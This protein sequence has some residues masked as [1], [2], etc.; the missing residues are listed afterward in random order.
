MS[1]VLRS[2]HLNFLDLSANGGTGI[3]FFSDTMS[4]KRLLFILRC[5]RFDASFRQSRLIV[6]KLTRSV[7]FV[8]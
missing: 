1:G 5:L 3:E 6:D 8:T 2:S 4:A 7:N